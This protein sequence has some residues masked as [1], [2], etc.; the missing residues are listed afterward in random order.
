MCN[1]PFPPLPSLWCTQGEPFLGLSLEF[2]PD[3]KVLDSVL[4]GV[5]P[6]LSD[7]D[8]GAAMLVCADPDS[9][10]VLCVLP[11]PSIFFLPL[12][13]LGCLRSLLP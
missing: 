6:L 5:C 2:T 1:M 11:L 9:D 8:K 7:E 3:K 10:K 12:V 4:N 13:A